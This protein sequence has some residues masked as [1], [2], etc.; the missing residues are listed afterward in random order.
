MYKVCF[1]TYYEDSINMKKDFL[2]SKVDSQ[3][4]IMDNSAPLQMYSIH[5]TA[6]IIHFLL[7]NGILELMIR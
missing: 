2:C 3:T 4:W 5:E 7:L 6:N 1:V